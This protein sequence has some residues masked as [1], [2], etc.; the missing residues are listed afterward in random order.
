MKCARRWSSTKWAA[1]CFREASGYSLIELLTALGVVSVVA[2]V[3]VPQLSAYAVRY[4]LSSAANQ[5]AV[6]LA[7]ARMKAIGENL[8]VRVQFGA[9]N[10]GTL[11]YG[12]TYQL[13]TSNDGVTFTN[14][15]PP[16]SIPSG[17]SFYASPQT[18]TFNRQGMAGGPVTVWAYN[19]A[20][21]WQVITMNSIGKVWV[22]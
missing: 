2:A 14:V 20:Y 19:Q 5:L 15:G 13:S 9:Q 1:R 16:T 4:R 8:Y 3:S 21:Q 10:I 18:V 17:V 6:D 11:G 22:Q 7:R 12:S